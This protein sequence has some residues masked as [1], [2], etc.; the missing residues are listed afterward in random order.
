[1]VSRDI[2]ITDA[3][4]LLLDATGEL[5]LQESHA[6]SMSRRISTP[7]TGYARLVKDYQGYRMVDEEYHCRLNEY[8]SG[9]L[10][11]LDVDAMVAAVENSLA[12]DKR[13]DV[14][15][16]QLTE[17]QAQNTVSFEVTYYDKELQ[18]AK[19]TT[20]ETQNV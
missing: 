18:E 13:I 9:P 17:Q 20:I 12:Y 1:M 3:G 4:D 14:L 19:T 2:S 15:D 10:T 16:V 11:S 8:L 5:V 7:L 6:P